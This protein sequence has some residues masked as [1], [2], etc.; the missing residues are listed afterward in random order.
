MASTGPP[1]TFPPPP[2]G[3]GVNKGGNRRKLFKAKPPPL[4]EKVASPKHTQEIVIQVSERAATSSPSS[5]PNDE[6]SEPV[7]SP[8]GP[9]STTDPPRSRAASPTPTTSQFAVFTDEKLAY[10][11]SEASSAAPAASMFPRYNP[12]LPLAE[13]NYRPT[14]TSPGHIS[15]QIISKPA[16]SP[17]HWSGR[18][19]GHPI[20]PGKL[21]PSP[22]T[23]PFSVTFFPT[24]TLGPARPHYSSP[25]DLLDLW[26]AANGQEIGDKGRTFALHVTREGTVDPSSNAFKATENESFSFGAS[27]A[28]PFYD[29]QTL[30][31][32]DVDDPFS[33]CNI[34]RH[35]PRNGTVI[36]I[37]TFVLPSSTE[38]PSDGQLTRLYPKIAAMMALD[39]AQGLVSPASNASSEDQRARIVSEAATKETYRLSWDSDSQQYYLL[40]PQVGTGVGRRFVI[41]IDG[42][43]GFD[44]HGARGT[45]RLAE[46]ETQRSLVA[47]E[48]GTPTLLIDTGAT[49]GVES[50]YTVD[51]CVSAVLAVAVFEGR[52][53]RLTHGRG[54]GVPPPLL[55]P[56]PPSVA[57]GKSCMADEAGGKATDDASRPLPKPAEGLLGA[58][59]VGFHFIIW[60]LSMVFGG[61]ATLVVALSACAKKE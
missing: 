24:G 53:L 28:K 38:A 22:T 16:Y 49:S 43:A 1:P 8:D 45:I 25:E 40:H 3:K 20:S 30:R 39:R 11:M 10:R 32:S 44:V 50:L 48:F 60:M 58:L 36:P 4:T 31:A 47:L 52:R 6:G 7:T 61:L 23:S 57:G 5:L 2:Q 55:S 19:P 27:K 37:M 21:L 14:Q 59:S 35:D 12:A 15:P 46:V 13:Q 9:R 42:V 17:V 51:V 34:R 41:I 26:E 56:P 54:I 33:E 29:M 18:S